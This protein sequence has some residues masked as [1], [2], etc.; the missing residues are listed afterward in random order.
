MGLVLRTQTPVV[1]GLEPVTPTGTP[2]AKRVVVF[3]ADGLRVRRCRHAATTAAAARIRPPSLSTIRRSNPHAACGV[4]ESL[5]PTLAVTSSSLPACGPHRVHHR[6]RGSGRR[7]DRGVPA[8]AYDRGGPRIEPRHESKVRREKRA[9][10]AAGGRREQADKLLEWERTADGGA[11]ARAPF[12]HHCASVRGRWGISHARPPTESRPGHVSIL[13]GFYE[14]PSAITKGNTRTDS[15]RRRA[16]E[17]ERER[18][19]ERCGVLR[20][21]LA[22]KKACVRRR[23]VA[24]AP[25]PSRAGGRNRSHDVPNGIVP[26]LKDAS[27]RLWCPRVVS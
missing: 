15:G 14:D 26:P 13:A 11:A 17:R 16:N 20:E 9:A 1:Q 19:T 21:K 2:I 27:C 12:L 10:G 8:V 24:L 18:E 6:R 22:T 3:V 7:H 5:N 25:R 4:S 23:M